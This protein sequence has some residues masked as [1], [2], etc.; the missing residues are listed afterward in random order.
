MAYASTC[1]VYALT[2]GLVKPASAFDSATCPTL[3]QVQ[4]WLS[5]GCSVIN[6]RLESVGYSAIGTGTTASE[7]AAAANA[8]YGAWMAER[9]RINARISADERT[10]ADQFKDDFEWHLDL[11]LG[12]DLSRAGVSQT[13]KAYAG[14]ISRSDK[15][16]VESDTDRVTPRFSRGMY[17]N[18]EALRPG[19]NS[20]S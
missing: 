11:L 19:P 3:T 12:L 5:S 18:A 13:S 9:S 2:P 15:S 20:A 4:F 1:D 14:G 16:T 17:D 8:L 6:A 10:R 7:L